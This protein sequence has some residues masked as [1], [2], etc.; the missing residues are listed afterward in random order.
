MTQLALEIQNNAPRDRGRTTSIP[1]SFSVAL[2]TVSM[3]N[4]L[5]ERN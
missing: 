3:P 2:D 5:R 1:S 4:I